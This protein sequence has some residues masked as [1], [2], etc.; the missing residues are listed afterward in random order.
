[1]EKVDDLIDVL[2]SHINAIVSSGKEDGNEVTEKT[3]ALAELMSARAKF[4][5][6]SNTAEAISGGVW[7]AVAE[8]AIG[9]SAKLAPIVTAD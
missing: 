7:S 2:A 6:Q 9:S 5:T 1:M 8:N 3:K 4:Q